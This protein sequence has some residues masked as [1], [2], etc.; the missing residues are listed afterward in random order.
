MSLKAK[1]SPSK[2]A[3]SKILLKEFSRLYRENVGDIYPPSWGRDLK[4]FKHLCELYG[5][6][7]LKELLEMYFQ[8]KRDMYSIPYFKLSVAELLQKQNK[9]KSHAPHWVQNSENWRYEE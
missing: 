3:D 2:D 4:L 7:R 5:V 1:K 9:A 8:E 6:D